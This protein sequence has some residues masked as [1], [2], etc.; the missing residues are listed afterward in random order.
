M[1]FVNK[2]KFFKEYTFGRI[3]IIKNEFY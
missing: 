3:I 2:F 1:F